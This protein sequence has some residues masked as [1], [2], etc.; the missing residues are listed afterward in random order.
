MG[1][2]PGS[3]KYRDALIM[4]PM[5]RVSLLPARLL[6]LD[7]GADLVYSEVSQMIAPDGTTKLVCAIQIAWFISILIFFIFFCVYTIFT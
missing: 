4:G 2:S 3:D 1:D 5:V 7:Y 6:G